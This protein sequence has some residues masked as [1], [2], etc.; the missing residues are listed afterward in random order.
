[1][2]RDRV[3]DIMNGVVEEKE[4]P[5]TDLERMK[6]ILKSINSNIIPKD[7]LEELKTLKDRLDNNNTEEAVKWWSTTD[8]LLDAHKIR[9]NDKFTKK[10]KVKLPDYVNKKLIEKLT[11]MIEEYRRKNGKNKIVKCKEFFNKMGLCED[12]F[13]EFTREVCGRFTFVT[14][15]Y[16]GEEVIELIP[17]GYV[18][19]RD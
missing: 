8:L 19:N 5:L 13:G 11:F 4:L 17:W 18:S 6:E 3:M 9:N 10:K 1:M 12:N 2:L 7:T 15:Y 16:N 14:F